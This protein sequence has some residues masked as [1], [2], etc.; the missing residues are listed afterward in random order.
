MNEEQKLELKRLPMDYL[1]EGLILKDNVYN[2]NGSVLLIPAGEIITQ[3][4]LKRLDAFSGKERY[5][6][7]AQRSFEVIMEHKTAN[8]VSARMSQQELEDNSGYTQLKGHVKDMLDE[9]CHRKEVRT[10]HVIS[11][12]KETYEIMETSNLSIMLNCIDTP[13]PMDEGLQRHSLN[14]AI[15]NGIIGRSMCLEEE[16]IRDLVLAGLLHD[17]GKTMIPQEILDAPRKLTEKEYA[18]VKK[19]PE[20]S[21]KIIGESVKE[22]IRKAVLYHHERENGKGYPEGRS[23]NIPLYARITAVADVYEALVAKRS[24]K[25]ARIPFDVLGKL[26]EDRSGLDYQATMML[27]NHMIGEFRGKQVLLSDGAE[28]EVCFVPSNDLLHPIV[29][30]G[31]VVRQTDDDWKCVR[32]LS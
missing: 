6:M 16:E 19:H 21:Y 31:G 15:L 25:E 26:I 12:A 23:N 2:Y 11:I 27:V 28:G 5:V 7:T 8:Q 17:V 32:L 29:L 24:Y 20:F 18:L 4:R 1:W 9:A 3:I 22:D 30:S 13:R 10:E 14:V